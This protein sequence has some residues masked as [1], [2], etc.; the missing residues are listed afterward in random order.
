MVT[1]LVITYICVCVQHNDF[2]YIYS[3]KSDKIDLGV[4]SRD[5]G[6][7]RCRCCLGGN[8]RSSIGGAGHNQCLDPGSGDTGVF[9][10]WKCIRLYTNGMC[11][12]I[13]VYNMPIKT[14]KRCVINKHLS[15]IDGRKH[16]GAVSNQCFENWPKP[17]PHPHQQSTV[18]GRLSLPPQLA[19]SA[20]GPSR[21]D[22][23]VCILQHPSF[24]RTG[25]LWPSSCQASWD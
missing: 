8:K 5:S 10:W 23:K 12:L 1:R 19:Q 17:L 18:L 7:P 25:F 6:Y 13:Y 2:L 22:G 9:N 16:I 4:K 20:N 14:F 3:T 24:T 11:I 15:L 21:A